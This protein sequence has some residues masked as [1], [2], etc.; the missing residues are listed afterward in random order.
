MDRKVI[1]IEEYSA[2]WASTFLQL[3]S[4]YEKH[5]G[6]LIIDIHH[7]GSTAVNNLAA[8][9]VID[10]DIVIGDKENLNAVISKLELLGY[11]HRGNLGITDRYAFKQ[12]TEKTPFDGLMR[13]W[14]KHHLYVCPQSSIS[15][16]NHITLRDVLRNN[17]VKAKE[18]G[19]LK[20]KLALE[21]P[22]DM[23]LYI[24]RK[25]PFITEIL[26]SAG[27][28]DAAINTITKENKMN[29]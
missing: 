18:Y 24:E 16:M 7:V 19:E 14:Q 15:L 4:I 27:F 28:S 11:S 17:E 13:S 23:D 6:D 26:K 22:Y 1:I 2:T 10:I 5:L 25:T 8:K 12:K 20:K 21:S 29:K 3:K 9:P